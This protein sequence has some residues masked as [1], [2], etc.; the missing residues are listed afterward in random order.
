MATARH[1]AAA[2]QA[3]GARRPG[4]AEV[5]IGHGLAGRLGAVGAEEHSNRGRHPGVAKP[6]L[7]GDLLDDAVGVGEGRVLHH[8]EHPLRLL[9]V[10]HQLATP[11]GDV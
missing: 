3:A 9:V 6:H 1:T 5:G 2:F 11:V 8:P 7:V 4:T 10:R